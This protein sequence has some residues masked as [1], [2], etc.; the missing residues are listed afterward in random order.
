M[1]CFVHNLV[2]IGQVVLKKK[3]KMRKV[4]RRTD[5]QTEYGQKKTFK[6]FL[7]VN[8]VQE[9]AQLSIFFLVKSNVRLDKLFSQVERQKSPKIAVVSFL[10]QQR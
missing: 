5:G 6:L 10:H 9:K 1:E 4:Y 2:E 8:L 7:L 3:F